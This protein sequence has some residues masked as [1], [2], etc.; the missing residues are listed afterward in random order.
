MREGGRGEIREGYEEE[1]GGRKEGGGSQAGSS[2]SMSI[3]RYTGF[4]VP[5][6]SLIFLI[7]PPMPIVSISLASTISNPQYPSLS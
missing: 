6:L 7:I 1:G 5:T 3:D 4:S 2:V